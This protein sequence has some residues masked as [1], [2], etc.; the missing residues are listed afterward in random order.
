MIQHGRVGYQQ[1]GVFPPS[2]ERKRFS[3]LDCFCT[4]LSI[5][6][7]VA[8]KSAADNRK[9]E[10]ETSKIEVYLGAHSRRGTEIGAGT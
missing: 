8:E 2:T 3:T 4:R 9:Q 1:Q 6:F 10:R 7:I 5:R